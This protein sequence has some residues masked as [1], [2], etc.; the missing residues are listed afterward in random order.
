MIMT[1]RQEIAEILEK[2]PISLFNLA[3]KLGVPLK[4]LL[5]DLEHI[6]LSIKPRQL[7]IIPAYCKSCGFVFR[8]RSR[9]KTPTKCPKCRGEWIE[10]EK[11]YIE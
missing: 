4:E 6:K 7:K 1:R 10:R 3:N 5:E 8:E 9:I 2:G 11:I